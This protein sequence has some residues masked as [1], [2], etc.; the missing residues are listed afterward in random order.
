MDRFI[1]VSF[2][3][4]R[5]ATMDVG[6]LSRS[7]HHIT[8]LLEVDI[9]D[10][11]KQVKKR[12]KTGENISLLSWLINIIAQTISEHKYIH[13]INYRNRSQILFDDVDI[14]LPIEKEVDGDKV[15]LAMLIKA[16]DKKSISDICREIDRAKSVDIE[17]EKDYVLSEN[18]NKLN[19]LFFNLPRFLRMIIWKYILNNPF[20]RKRYM[21]TA[22]VTN[23][24]LLSNTSGW[25]IPKSMH[26][27]CFAIGS[28]TKKPWIRNNK[29]EIRDILHLTL[30]FDHDSVDGAPAAKFTRSLVKN[31]E[32]ANGL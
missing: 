32:S 16:A 25:I 29:I 17:D 22:V 15:P 18:N 23:V 26:N 2:P 19:A 10:A 28:I 31:I 3:K 5:L 27:I 11:R 4:S 24:G 7:K 20:R 21:G 1:K 9:T 8:G 30:I 12:V 13:S 14:S 6:K